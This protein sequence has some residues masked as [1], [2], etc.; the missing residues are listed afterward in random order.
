MKREKTAQGA[1]ILYAIVRAD[2]AGD[3][4][5][6]GTRVYQRR[7]AAERNYSPGLERIV[8]VIFVKV[9]DTVKCPA[10]GCGRSTKGHITE[11]RAFG[12]IRY[13]KCPRCN[14][15]GEVNNKL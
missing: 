5:P 12:I 2:D 10:S 6:P 15:T 13:V 1:P 11:I 4:L 7:E 3:V 9:P 14:G 8:K